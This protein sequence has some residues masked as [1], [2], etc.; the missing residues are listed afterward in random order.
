MVLKFF[1]TCTIIIIWVC[2]QI[3][4]ARGQ[5]E[6]SLPEKMDALV[7]LDENEFRVNGIN[8]AKFLKHRV[9]QIFNEKGKK[10]GN[11]AIYEN[12]YI[13]VKNIKGSMSDENG[14]VI[15]K[16]KKEDINTST[17]SGGFILYS[18]NKYFWFNFPITE[19]PVTIEYS[20]EKD[21]SSLFF[22]PD[23]KPQEDIPVLKSSYRLSIDDH[24]Q[25][26]THSIGMDIEPEVSHKGGKSIY[27]WEL[28]GIESRIREDFMP[29]EKR[30]QKAI[31]F[32][33]L[34][35]KFGDY[36]GSFKTWND[37]GKWYS[38]LC[39]GKFDLPPSG[40]AQ[41]KQL[42]KENDSPRE[43]IKKLYSFLQDYTRYVAIY[44]DIGGWQPH[45]V[46]SIY[47]NKYGDCKDLTTLMITMLR[48]AGIESYPALLLTRDDGAVI[49]E[50][51]SNQFNHMIAFVPLPD[52][53]LWLE[54]TADYLPPG[55]LPYTAEGCNVVVVKNLG[56][57]IVRTP[58]ST[59][60]DNLFRSKVYGKLDMFGTLKF[61]AQFRA[62]GNQCNFYRT[63]FNYL[64]ASEQKEWIAK[65]L[66]AY[67][68]KFDLTEFSISNVSE[69]F[70]HP[71]VLQVSG[72]IQKFARKSASR[73]FFNLNI[74]NRITID[75]IPDEAEREFPVYFN[76]RFTDVDTV[77]IEI[78]DNFKLES[79]PKIRDIQRG[80]ANF[81]TSVLLDD[82][83]LLYSRRYSIDEKQIPTESYAAYLD[84]MKTVAK[85]DRSKFVL[86]RA[87]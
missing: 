82:G 59:A 37:F 24:L 86:K 30:L 54:C 31:L 84:F 78:P 15:K 79:T 25:F 62:Y 38:S 34:K 4:L 21:I 49:T 7:V 55:E 29:P 16:I 20:Y 26:K 40:E 81:R 23:W 56:G 71:V 52:D 48:Q 11:V 14:K 12:K 73:I 85:N 57:E 66:G 80:F 19:F 83:K 87:Y 35:F 42:V 43:K 77:I 70:E 47:A 10:Y 1:R 6:I 22:W 65:R 46:K 39:A 61:T 60:R 17:V 74:F 63:K 8:S 28:V 33:P 2:L 13:K 44:L 53:S 69:N 76:Y 5:A 50:F 58:Q 68:P 3:T 32:A 18:E 72:K 51:P 9:V 41:I 27:D 67:Y 64:K 45:S 36:W 75:D